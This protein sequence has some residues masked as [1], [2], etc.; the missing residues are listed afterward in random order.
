MLPKSRSRWRRAAAA[1]SGL[2]PK[3]TWMMKSRFEAIREK[4]RLVPFNAP[5]VRQY[6]GTGGGIGVAGGDGAMA[7]CRSGGG[8]DIYFTLYHPHPADAG[9]DIFPFYAPLSKGRA[10]G[11]RG[12][13]GC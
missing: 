5:V 9:R 10:A 11:I 6:G 8:G 12:A 4:Y 1:P 3:T 2:L 7:A 13:G